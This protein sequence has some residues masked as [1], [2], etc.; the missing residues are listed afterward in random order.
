MFGGLKTR[1]IPA[2]ILEHFYPDR[3]TVVEMNA[4]DFALG[5][6]LSQF[7]EKW[8]HPVGFHSR[9]LNNA[10]RNY[11]I[12]DKELFAMLEA[13]KE[14][15]HYLVGS[16]KPITVYTDHQNLQN[17]LTT[18]VWNR[19]WV[20]WAQRLADYNFKIIYRP[21]GK[22]EKPDVLSRQPEYC[23]KEGAEHNE[24]SILKSEHFGLSLIHADDKDEGY[25]SELEQVL[26]QAIRIKTLS[27]KATLVTKGSWLA[28][29]DNIY[30]INEFTM[31]AQGY[32]LAEMGIAIRLPKGTY[33]RIAPWS[34]L[35]S[36]KGIAI[37]GSVIDADYTG[38][39]KVIM[40][41]QGKIDCRIQ[42]G[43]RIAQ[44]IIEKID[45]ADMMEV[46][47][48]EVT[49]WADKGFGSTD[50]SPKR[51]PPVTDCKPIICFLQ[52]NYQDNEYFDA[53]DMGD[54]RNC[55]KNIS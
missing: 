27:A 10:G 43:D 35:A 6:V 3:E 30:V 50:M 5:C 37:N 49:K 28:A 41:N 17:F 21:G 4:S 12:H 33:A 31:P 24:Q 53:E 13:F 1:F 34:G 42:A 14:W 2:P 18:K 16:D 29:G 23:P 45:T 48:L 44:L 47:N 20:R 36:K 9:K 51:T 39:V 46:G 40:I 15:K 26:Q 38:E 7:K 22:G 8:L 54:T 55:E 32:V 25:V 52:V 11:E 19:Q